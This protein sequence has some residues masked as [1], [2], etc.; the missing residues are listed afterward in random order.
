MVIINLLT[1]FICEFKL[2]VVQDAS[3]NISDSH[4]ELAQWL[5]SKLL[6]QE[7]ALFIE[8]RNGVRMRKDA[9]KA[10]PSGMSRNEAFALYESWGGRDCLLPITDCEPIKAIMDFLGG[11]SLLDFVP[12]DYAQQAE[13]ALKQLG[14]SEI[15]MGNVWEIFRDLLDV[16]QT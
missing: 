12:P 16:L 15:N 2:S 5:W 8:F 1:L 14:I 10:G 6:R 4:S 9:K 11:S 3:L 13:A 7:L